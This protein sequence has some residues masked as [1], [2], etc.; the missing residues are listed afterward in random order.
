[1]K[2]KHLLAG[3]ALTLVAALSCAAFTGCSGSDSQAEGEKDTDA[4]ETEYAPIAVSYLNKTYYEDIIVGDA[5]GFFTDCG[6][7]V[8]LNVVEGSGQQSV[9]ALLGGSVDI[10]AT[11]Q[12]PVADAIK[13]Y[14]DDIVILAGTNC[15]TGEQAWVAGPNMVGDMAITPYDAATDN[16]ADV[17]ASFENAAA[18]KGSPILIGVQNG[19]T[20]AGNLKSWLKGM[21]ISFNDFDTEGDGVVSLVDLKAN[22]LATT[23]ATGTDI[24]IMAAS[25]PFPNTA[26]ES[27]EGSYQ[28]G[29]NAD[30]N[31]YNAMLLIT[32]KEIY[33]EKE[34]SIKAFL[35]ADKKATDFMNENPDEAIT[36]CAE[37]M[38]V[39]EA[40]VKAIFDQ[41]AFQTN[42]TDQMVSTLAKA[43]KSKEVE[44]T[45]DELKAQMPLFDWLNNELNK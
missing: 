2:K 30:T 11:G 7:E 33:A 40:N 9:E 34:D 8:T 4:A 6:P 27:V 20:T 14:G 45:E 23:L 10:A 16:K 22:T 12:G 15:M 29:T 19:S 21:E 44:I 3:A 38:G 43:C 5:K 18:A 32:T 13:Q 36:I 1:M 37:S 24:D 26:L 28:I 42:L 25:Q 39:D 17:K 35:E 31:T 41:A